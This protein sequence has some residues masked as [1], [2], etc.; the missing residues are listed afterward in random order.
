MSTS[1]SRSSAEKKISSW[2]RPGVLEVRANPL[3]LVSALIRLDLPTLERPA[4]A[5][6]KP[7]IAGSEAGVA[8]A[9]A[10]RQSPA[11]SRRP[12]PT[13]LVVKAGCGIGVPASI[14]GRAAHAGVTFFFEETFDAAPYIPEIIQQFDLGAVAAHDDGLLGHRQRVVPRPINYEARGERRQHEGEDH[15]HPI[16]DHLLR[17]IGRRR[18]ELH[19]EP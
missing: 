2:V 16:E 10:K 18:I 5:N 7:F 12:A 19:L 14:S 17:R 3:R 6:S 4:K 9:A 13:S 11:N 15:R 8:A 1:V